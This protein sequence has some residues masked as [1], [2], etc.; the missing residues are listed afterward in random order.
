LSH[1]KLYYSS[2]SSAN[3]GDASVLQKVEKIARPATSITQPALAGKFFISAVDKT[4]NE[5]TSAASTII[6]PSELPSLG[7]SDTDTEDPTFSG[8]KSN[9][10]VS[11]GSLFMT[12]YSA[13]GSTGTYDFDHSGNGYFDVGTSRTVRLSSTITVSR[14]H[15]D[16][17][18]GEV[19]WDDI[20]QNW[21]TW[22][23]N[24]DTW[25]NEDADFA[26]YAVQ[27]QARAADT[28]GGLS[29]ATF[30]DAGGEIVGRYIEFR[31][32]L[33]NTNAKISPNITALSA[34][35]EY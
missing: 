19:N 8:S 1:Y 28:T 35:V 22:P 15:E 26:D 11:S 30:V 32:I 17:V 9:L 14:K 24:W 18:G 16:A 34:T 21:D 29:S 12:S 10:T 6:T 31:A 27:I 33:S 3:F 5:S 20:P 13:S 23:D 4:G 25:T 2:N 7:Q